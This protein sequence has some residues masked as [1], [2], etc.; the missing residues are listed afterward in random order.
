MLTTGGSEGLTS[1][2]GQ[3]K[4]GLG[5]SPRNVEREPVAPLLPLGSLE[6]KHRNPDD[7]GHR[8]QDCAHH[9]VYHVIADRLSARKVLFGE[10]VAKEPDAVDEP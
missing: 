9:R 8:P 1:E 6:L 4:I 2:S 7:D 5:D 3:V 10:G